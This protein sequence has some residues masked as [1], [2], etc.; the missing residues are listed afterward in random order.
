M[1][2]NNF[3]TRLIW[4]CVLPL[5][6]LSVYLAGHHIHTLQAQQDVEAANL[7]RNVATALDHNLG[8]RISALQILAAS[9][10][11]D[12]PPRLKE[13]YQEAHGFRENFGGGV[14]L[15]DLTMQMLLNTR[16]PFGAALPKLP[17]PKGSVVPSVLATGKPTVGNMSFGPV[18]KEPL[19][20]VVLPVIRNGR[21][22]ELLLN[23]IETRLFQQRIDKVALPAGWCLTLLDGNNEVMARRAPPEMIKRLVDMKSPGFFV[24]KL[25][26]SPWSVVLEIPQDAYR[27]PIISAATALVVAI[28]AV[29]L[30]S[31]LGGR[32]ASRRLAR[33]VATLKTPPF[34]E[35]ANSVILEIEAV[36]A[37]LDAA[38]TTRDLAETALRESE[39]EFRT[40]AEAMPQI[41]WITRP[42]GWNIYFNQQWMDYTGMT[43]EESYG[44]GWNKPFHP[45]DQQR[46]WDAWQQAMAN[47]GIYSL[48]CRLRRADGTYRWWL[49]RGVPVSDAD[50]KV[51]KWFGTCTDIEDI[52]LT[53][54]ALRESE[55]QFRIAQE[56]SP[57]GFTILRPLRDAMGRVADFTWV[58]ENAMIARLNGTE[59]K[60][61]VGRRLLE[62]FP[63]H[64]GS[65]FMSA[66]QQVAES[67]EH[68]IF[69]AD[70]KG[71]GNSVPAWLRIVVVPAGKDIAIL[72]QDITER[73]RAEEALKESNARL[74]LFVEHAP[75]SLAMFDRNMCY[76]QVSRR[77]LDDYGL[78]E[79]NLQGLSHYDVFPEL[80]DNWKEAHR[81]GLAGEVVRA[82]A[83][84]FER[85]D[86]SVQW[87]RWEVRPW[88][89]AKGKIGGIVIFIED[90]TDRKQS[91]EVLRE[92]EARTRNVFDQANDGIYI[93]SAENHYLD[94]NE[95]GLELLGYTR[96]ELLQLNVADVLNPHE[97]AR[98][99]VEPP[100]MMSGVPHLAEWVHLRKDGTTFPGEVSARRLNDYSYLAIVRDLSE[101]RRA[102]MALAESEKSFR[103]SFEQAAVGMAR[104]GTDGRWL[105]VN[106][107]LCDIVGYTRDELL[108]LTFLDITHPD[109]LDTDLANVQQV[110]AGDIDTYSIEKRYIRK[111]Q[112]ITWINLT[113]G[114][115]RDSSG[116]PAYFISVVEDINARKQAEENIHKLNAELEERV[117]ERTIQLESLN[118]ELEAFSYSVSHDLKAPLRGIDGYSQLLER[119]YSDRL[120]DEGRQFIRN[121]RR[122]AAQMYELIEAM[123]AYSR[124]ERRTLQSVPLD[125]AV[126]VQAVV[127]ER[128][129]VI[130]QSGTQMHV[131]VPVISVCAD[132]DGLAVV[133]RNLLEN[134]L[135]F[136]RNSQ[137]PM[138]DIGAGIEG[139]K[140]IL[141]VR[142]NGIGFDM[143]FY[144]RIFE[145]FQ[146][147]E[148]SEDYPGT[149]VG[150][151]LVRKAMVRMGG[152]VWAESTP[153]GGATFFLEIPL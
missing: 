38:A 8:A 77:C 80:Q 117:R 148:R 79:R 24:A 120:D 6:I 49:I 123:L 138:V 62:L 61:V 151:A 112:R 122:G 136:S 115:V 73:K 106:Q 105:E 121:I 85:A 15:A 104:V 1:S 144:D 145:I 14:I 4:L 12:D 91:E 23:T 107:R 84:C 86:G 137:P 41:V 124:M 127:A 133:L 69:E 72:A 114:L 26:V 44:H 102:E 139:D 36:R 39:Q 60:A 147:L 99:A 135:K 31:V 71:E 47:T 108:V 125:L 149:G 118:K 68:C 9:P 7:A 17:Q 94:V 43:L 83:D 21:K 54:E 110:L 131:E 129:A 27:K 46:A 2:L 52:K 48:E 70:Y 29:T 134:A 119:E 153:G 81:R 63:G 67:G 78:G 142:D 53:E 19:V 35:N 50:G 20:S 126:L 116:V 42:D 13:F 30:I 18:A 51:L 64:R 96:D 87:L 57:D 25:T 3:L 100:Q 150:L 141:W 59:P 33:S 76:V 90:I 65:K 92:S 93:I 10:L 113:V 11:I 97:V 89:D 128:S 132:R 140:A 82:E 143:K 22:I 28:L 103:A 111:D 40:L 66:Y 5:V 146:R 37:M 75:A 55:E 152:R 130:E 88:L 74:Q 56:L 32:L 101:R 34:L 45:D 95:R 58:Y 16:V 109:D 98:L